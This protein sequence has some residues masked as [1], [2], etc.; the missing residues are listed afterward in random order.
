MP[1]SPLRQQQQPKS[2]SSHHQ[3]SIDSSEQIWPDETIVI[4]PETPRVRL[5]PRRKMN[6]PNNTNTPGWPPANIGN[7]I[8]MYHDPEEEEEIQ[9]STTVDFTMNRDFIESPLRLWMFWL[10][11]D[12]QSFMP[13]LSPTK[14]RMLSPS[15]V[16]DENTDP[17]MAME[18]DGCIEIPDSAGLSDETRDAIFNV[19]ATQDTHDDS[20]FVEGVHYLKVPHP[21]FPTISVS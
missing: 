1:R 11:V 14:V 2:S 15:K 3:L 16:R 18:E 19:W 17:A 21:H 5:S 6:P 7:T 9:D 4:L 20:G 8:R 13:P 12:M 10:M